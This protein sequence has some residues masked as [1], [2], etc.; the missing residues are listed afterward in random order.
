MTWVWVFLWAVFAAAV[1]G[2]QGWSVNILLA[3]KKAWREFAS[4]YKL[5]VITP[6]KWL[7]P[8]ALSG[9]LHG[10][11]LNVYAEIE[12][13]D[14][15]RTQR[16]YSH[17]EVFLNT[18]PDT[19]AAFSCKPLPDAL[20][21]LDLP[22]VFTSL[23]PDW[24]KPAVAVTDDPYKLANWLNPARMRTLRAFMESASARGDEAML[25]VDHERAFLLWRT[26]NPLRDPRTL[27]ALV[28]KLFS[29]A[30]DMDAAAAGNSANPKAES[31][32]SA[33]E[34]SA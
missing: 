4:R 30:G 2:F 28:Q 15:E 17:I 20:K 5:D 9:T 34:S 23:S 10:R 29:F 7:E 32:I 33:P 24:P 1:L 25:L 18:R 16:I 14:R 21:W 26:D 27:N 3:Q 12:Q 13:T 8:V 6:K 31:A 11:R 19:Y 22:Q